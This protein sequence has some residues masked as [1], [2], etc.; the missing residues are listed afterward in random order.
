MS[1]IILQNLI[2]IKYILQKMIGKITKICLVKNV[3]NCYLN[4]RNYGG[5]FYV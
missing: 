1:E 2:V 4:R 5:E 3:Q